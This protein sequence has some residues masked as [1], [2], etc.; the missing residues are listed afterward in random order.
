MYLNHSMLWSEDV[1]GAVEVYQA[2]RACLISHPLPA[3]TAYRVVFLPRCGAAHDDDKQQG[4]NAFAYT[5]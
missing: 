3:F 5:G 4:F 1:A 2:R